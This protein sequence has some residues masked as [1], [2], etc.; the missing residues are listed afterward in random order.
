MNKR[1]QVSIEFILLIVITLVYIYGTVWPLINDAIVAAEDVQ[2]VSDTKI[3]AQKLANAINEAAAGSGESKRTIHLLI[4]NDASIECNSADNK[5]E[6]SVEVDNL[7]CR[8]PSE[9]C[10]YFE[11]II[12]RQAD[13]CATSTASEKYFKCSASI[14]MIAGAVPGSCP[15]LVGPLFDAIVVEKPG[16]A[17]SVSRPG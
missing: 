9:E 16:G 3:S 13:T 2:R 15:S 17:I 14:S 4:P 12:Q 5:I 6:Y 10:L 8:Q 11:G 7:Y 1:G